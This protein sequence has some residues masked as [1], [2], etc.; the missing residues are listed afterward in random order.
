MTLSSPCALHL[1]ARH[2]GAPPAPVRIEAAPLPPTTAAGTGTGLA[3]G[4]FYHDTSTGTLYYQLAPGQTEADL[5]ANT[6]IA[7]KEALVDYNNTAGHAWEN[8]QFS[9]STWMQPNSPDGFVDTQATVFA[10]TPGS[11]GCNLGSTGEPLGAVRVSSSKDVRFTGCQFTH[12]GS[13]YALSVLGSSKGVTVTGSTFTDLSGGFLKLGSVGMD[14]DRTDDATWDEGFTVT[15]NIAHTQAI[16]YGGAPGYFGGFIAHSTI[17]HNTVS[18]AGYSGF[19]QGWGWGGTHAPGYGNVTLS[20][21][22]I[23]NVMAKMKDGGGIY[24]NGYTNDKYT[25]VMSHNWVNH[26]EHVFAV[27]Y[28]DN[29]ASHWHVTQNVA[30]NSSTQ[31]AFFMT[32]GTGVPSNAGHNNTVDHLWYALLGGALPLPLSLPPTPYASFTLDAVQHSQRE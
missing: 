25:N 5:N 8:V 17:S 24:V 11:E 14:N 9:Y 20:Y 26:D 31:W 29:G 23:F 3:G 1:F 27:Y 7:V 28:L 10:C 6:W 13:A 16:E 15:H 19:S 21:N 12:L 2:G 4:D 30:G 32:P 18:D 22:R